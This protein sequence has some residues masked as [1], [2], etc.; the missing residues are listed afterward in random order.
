MNDPDTIRGWI[1]RAE[2]EVADLSQQADRIQAEVKEARRRLM[3]LYEVL[4]TVTSSPVPVSNEQLGGG[5]SIRQRAQANAEEIL[6]AHGK[7]MSIQHIHAEFIR[8]GM[9]LPGRGSP[10]NILAHLSASDRF[11]RKG[12]GVYGLTEWDLSSHSAK[13]SPPSSSPSREPGDTARAEAE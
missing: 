4:A 8:R 5:R 2:A 6:R 7:P 13:S 12:R 3:L 1:T 9:P 11:S 10:T